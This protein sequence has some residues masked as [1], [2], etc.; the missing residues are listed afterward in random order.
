MDLKKLIEEHEQIKRNEEL[1]AT[2][3]KKEIVKRLRNIIPI[4]NYAEYEG[5]SY[6]DI[7]EKVDKEFKFKVPDN[8]VF[9]ALGS[10]EDIRNEERKYI[11][12]KI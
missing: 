5:I 3:I 12:K 4:A 9:D 1:T 6:T 2:F 7:K 11:I 8:Y 10:M